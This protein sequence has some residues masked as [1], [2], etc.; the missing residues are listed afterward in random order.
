MKGLGRVIWLKRCSTV[1]EICTASL[2]IN[3]I[4]KSEMTV[5]WLK[6]CSIV[7]AISTARLLRMFEDKERDPL[8]TDYYHGLIGLVPRIERISAS[9]ERKSRQRIIT[10]D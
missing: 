1:Q 6:R 10:T 2:A 3:A 7:P 5:I 9:G 4:T 8:T